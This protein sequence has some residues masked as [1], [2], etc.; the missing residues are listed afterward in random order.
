MKLY[1]L[2]NVIS[3]VNI[4]LVCYVVMDNSLTVRL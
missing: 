1:V 2:Y 3:N 4:L